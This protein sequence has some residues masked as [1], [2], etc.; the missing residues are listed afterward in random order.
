MSDDTV[1][2]QSPLSLSAEG[3]VDR[4]CDRYES[5]WLTGQRPRLKHF[6]DGKEEPERSALLRELL[7]LL[8]HYLREDQ[9]QRWQQGERPAVEAYLQEDPPL[10]EY[11]EYVWELVCHELTLRAQ[12]GEMPR[13]EDYLRRFPAHE[14]ALRQYFATRQAPPL[15]AATGPAPVGL[16][17][18]AG[19]LELPGYRLE[20][21]LGRGGMGVVYRARQLSPERLVALKIIL[22]GGQASPEELQRFQREMEIVAHLDHPHVVPLYEAGIHAGQPYYSMQ[23]IEGESLA[24]QVQRFH[25]DFRATARL[26]ASAGRAVHYAHQRGILHRD[27]KPANILLDARGEPHVTDFGLARRLEGESSLTQSGVILGSIHYMAPEQAAGCR[28]VTTSADVYSLGVVLYE[29]LTG[30]PPFKAENPLETL[31]QIRRQEPVRP[32]LLSPKVPCDLETISLKCLEKDPARRYGSAEALA[33]DL[34]RW[35]DGVPIQ[36]RPVRL[37]ERLWKW[38]RRKPDLAV[39]V[40]LLVG[41]ALLSA[42]VV[43]WQSYTEASDRRRL[44]ELVED[45]KDYR[46]TI[47]KASVS[48]RDTAVQL[49]DGCKP[50]MRGLEWHFLQD[51]YRSRVWVI[52]DGRKVDGVLFSPHGR[53]LATWSIDGDV[54]VYDTAN[55]VKLGQISADDRVG[56]IP[57]ADVFR[58]DHITLNGEVQAGSDAKV[59]FSPDGKRLAIATA[60]SAQVWDIDRG[61]VERLLQKNELP[62]PILYFSPDGRYLVAVGSNGASQVYDRNGKKLYALSWDY[63]SIAFSPDGDLL[64]VANGEEVSVRDAGT[65]EERARLVGARGPVA[66]RPDGKQLFTAGQGNSDIEVWDV[67]SWRLLRTCSLPG[68]GRIQRLQFSPDG[69]YFMANDCL[70]LYS[71]FRGRASSISFS[72]RYQ[73][74][75]LGFSADSKRFLTGAGPTGAGRVSIWDLPA[76]QIILDLPSISGS[77]VL[78]GKSLAWR[79]GSGEIT[80]LSPP[81]G[82]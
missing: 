48:D 25:Q 34:Q 45:P 57:R 75:F 8:V 21:E 19:I 62:N 82:E 64:V 52:D 71:S 12:Q 36:A 58:Q 23:L 68:A 9:R 24:K 44:I 33:D 74:S 3:R 15:S 47:F 66:Y 22:A 76:G 61:Q 81:P 40:L 7:R 46:E 1:Q 65:G 5:A 20:S 28:A 53:R 6:L 43:G 38:A 78:A 72:V 79:S 13:L 70:Y 73:G 31:R 54:T 37:R 35:L 14:A 26:L 69:K 63:R 59:V 10:C 17:G 32:R 27:L 16:P 11:P 18:D 77:V 2:E 56:M 49:L 29:L 80:V 55:R 51:I 4:L 50:G 42:G 60:T 30:K 39:L 41:A 67:P